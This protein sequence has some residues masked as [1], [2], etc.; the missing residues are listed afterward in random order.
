MLAGVRAD[1]PG[2]SSIR[3]AARSCPAARASRSTSA[4]RRKKRK[5]GLSAAHLLTG[6]LVPHWGEI[7][8]VGRA[9]K[10][11]LGQPQLVQAPVPVVDGETQRDLVGWKV[12][13]AYRKGFDDGKMDGRKSVVAEKKAAT[14]AKGPKA[15]KKAKMVGLV[16][17]SP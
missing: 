7:L 14:K 8:A 11:G 13:A 10:G 9:L 6:R 5:R 2:R 12:P 4:A 17:L 16:E 3:S 15:A 1:A